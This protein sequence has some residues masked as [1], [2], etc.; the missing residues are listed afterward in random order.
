MHPFEARG[1]EGAAFRGP[2]RGATFHV[3]RRRPRCRPSPVAVNPFTA[4]DHSGQYDDHRSVCEDVKWIVTLAQWPPKANT[5]VNHPEAHHTMDILTALNPET[6]YS[7]RRLQ[8]VLGAW[9]ASA[10]FERKAKVTLDDGHVNEGE[11]SKQSLYA[12]LYSMYREIG[13]VKTEHGEPYE[14]TFN[15]WGY[16]WPAGWGDAPHGT[17][18]QRFGKNAYRG[19]FEFKEV[20]AYAAARQGKIHLVEMGCGTGA[21]AHHIC[22]TV[23]PECTYEAFDMQSAG[24]QTCNRKFV[25]ELNGRLVATHGDVTKLEIAANSADFVVICETHITEMRGEVTA[26]D[27]QFFA[28]VLNTLKPGGFLVWGNAIPELTWQPCFDHLKSIGMTMVDAHDVTKE[29]VVARDLDKARA[30]AYVEQCLDTF[31]A[32]KIP[33]LGKRRAAQARQALLNFYRN[34]GTR[35]YNNMVDGTDTYRVALFQKPMVA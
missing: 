10:A 35:L 6:P 23:W 15:T 31:H 17:D 24:V 11:Y 29:A 14:F 32:F 18:P 33:V 16:E 25:P 20:Q 13:T 22:K 3:D 21:G 8:L 19:L 4:V 34:P 9:V 26:H 5:A 7:K 12:L 27:K 30:D 2:P 1:P 28:K